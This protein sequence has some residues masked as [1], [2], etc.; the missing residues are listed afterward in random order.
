[1]R[2]FPKVKYPSH[3]KTDGLLNDDVVVTEKIDGANLRLK[4]EDGDI[5]IGTKN[6][7]YDI[8]D[9]NLP[10]AFGHVVERVKGLPDKT[11]RGLNGAGTFFGEAMHLHS[12]DYEDIDWET[13][14]K[15]SPH[16]P[17]ESDHPNVVFFD[18]W[19]DGQW[20]D[21]RSLEDISK[22]LDLPL[23]RVLDKGDP[24][25]VSFDVPEQSMFGGPPEGIVVRRL[26]GCVRAK[27]VTVDFKEK[28]AVSFNNPA[29]AQSDA[30]EFV[31]M[32]ITPAR[33]E[34]MAHKLVDRGEYDS[35]QMKMM[36]QLPKE[37]LTDVMAEEGWDLLTNDFECEFDDDFKG[38][39]RSKTSK[40][41]V[42]I[43]KE[44]IQEF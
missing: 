15:G 1:M 5:K 13:P 2:K 43:L 22:K 34:K 38:E 20:C 14:N 37:V 41:C 6:H 19:Q 27:K 7:S 32:Y 17:L 16:V 8:D 31:A 4:I 10:K 28:N 35:L 44:T 21:W 11:K 12:L 18:W 26:D 3:E 36:E 39:V 24:D 9:E 40:R 29:K 33:V 42:R 23:V 30:A 25:D